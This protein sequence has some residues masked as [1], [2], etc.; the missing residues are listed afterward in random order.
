MSACS[1]LRLCVTVSH[2]YRCYTL[3]SLSV[4]LTLTPAT[5]SAS[6]VPIN[7]EPNRITAC[8][9]QVVYCSESGAV[10][11][12]F[13][14][15]KL[16]RY[17]REYLVVYAP[18]SDSHARL[19]PTAETRMKAP[20]CQVIPVQLSGSEPPTPGRC[21]STPCAFSQLEYVLRIMTRRSL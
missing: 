10:Y 13:S 6:E 7:P 21:C 4:M 19:S 11:A 1:P 9:K 18:C 15:I 17:F 12:L 8:V 16:T 20:Q 3:S 14:R 2:C 5:R